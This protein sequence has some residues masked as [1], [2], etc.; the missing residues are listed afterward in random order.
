MSARFTLT[1]VGEGNDAYWE[2]YDEQD[3]NAMPVSTWNV[4]EYAEAEVANLNES[5]L[6]K[7]EK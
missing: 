5:L 3:V 6:Q 1:E 2:V 7:E 4:K